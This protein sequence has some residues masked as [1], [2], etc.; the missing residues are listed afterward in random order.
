MLHA[1][2][3]TSTSA[4]P[5]VF[6]AHS[7]KGLLLRDAMVQ[8]NTSPNQGYKKLLNLFS[9]AVFFGVPNLGMEQEHLLSIVG[10][11]PNEDLLLDI[12]RGSN[13]LKHLNTSYQAGSF[14]SF[15]SRWAY[16]TK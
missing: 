10:D 14:G 2:G 5:I 13:Y 12:A 8:L 16:E 6:L 11:N 15:Q 3:W 4:K 7:L 9:G 1:Y